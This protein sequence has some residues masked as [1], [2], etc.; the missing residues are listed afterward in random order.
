MFKA[1][2]LV[3][4]QGK[5]MS[6]RQLASHDQITLTPLSALLRILGPVEPPP[7]Y[8]IILIVTQPR[9]GATPGFYSKY[10]NAE[11]L[12]NEEIMYYP[13]RSRTVVH[14]KST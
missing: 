11:S 14:Y 12:R 5:P 6:C 1:C 7:I 10:A 4:H 9:T 2:D 8:S 13:L 3:C